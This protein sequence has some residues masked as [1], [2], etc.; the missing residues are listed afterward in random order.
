VQTR[1][2]IFEAVKVTESNIA[3]VREWINGKTL[4]SRDAEGKPV[5]ISDDFR[6]ALGKIGDFAVNEPDGFVFYSPEVFWEK[7]HIK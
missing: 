4:L 2:E 3:D 6:H 1:P 7:Y 5:I